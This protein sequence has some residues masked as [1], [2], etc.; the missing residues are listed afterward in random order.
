MF[1]EFTRN[2]RN[3]WGSAIQLADK[4][5]PE[6]HFLATQPYSSRHRGLFLAYLLLWWY[7]HS[8]R[9]INSCANI[10]AAKRKHQQIIQLHTGQQRHTH[11]HNRKRQSSFMIQIS[12]MTLREKSDRFFSSSPF[13]FSFVSFF[14]GEIIKRI[15]S[16]TDQI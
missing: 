12:L 1:I 2:A 13:C 6:G 9:P 14:L 5:A 10:K 16:R 8:S 15:R 7:P 4:D 3:N 11:T